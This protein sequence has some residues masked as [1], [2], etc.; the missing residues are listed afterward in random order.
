MAPLGAAGSGAA[1]GSLPDPFTQLAACDTTLLGESLGRWEDWGGH[2]A[3][4][5]QCG[6]GVELCVYT[7]SQLCHH[8]VMAENPWGEPGV[9]KSRVPSPGLSALVL[10]VDVLYPKAP[11]PR[12]LSVCHFKGWLLVSSAVFK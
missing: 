12:L 5:E 7:W 8:S 3:P 10:G 4:E 1:L 6:V 2:W 9:P 11:H